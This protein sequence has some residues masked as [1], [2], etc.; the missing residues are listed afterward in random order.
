MAVAQVAASTHVGLTA[1]QAETLDLCYKKKVAVLLLDHPAIASSYILHVLSDLES[2]REEDNR[3]WDSLSGS[4]HDQAQDPILD[5]K[6]GELP[7]AW[8]Q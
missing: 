4:H 6:E 2:L 1:D 8:A 3:V 7:S 5:V